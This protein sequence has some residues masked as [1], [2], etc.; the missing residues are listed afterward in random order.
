[1]KT[2]ISD[3]KIKIEKKHQAWL[4]RVHQAFKQGPR[5]R[6]QLIELLHYAKQRNL[7]NAQALKM[8]EGVLQISDIHVRDIMIPHAKITVI[9]E[10]A[11]LSELLPLVI[12]SGHSR[13]PLINNERRVIG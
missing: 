7:L 8:L 1:M 12:E 9:T 4:T 5:N 2:T 11:K 3:D 10:K 6:Q 13:F